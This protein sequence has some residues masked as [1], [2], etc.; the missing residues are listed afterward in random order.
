MESVHASPVVPF[1]HLLVQDAAARR[2]PL[3]V[4]SAHFALIAQAVAVFD[5]AGKNVGDRLNPSV[6]MPRKSG[7]VIPRIV[8]AKI[9]QQKKRIEIL[10]LAEAER[11]LQLDARALDGRLGLNN[12]SN[13]SE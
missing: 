10:R 1:R 13:W 7:Q 3:H 12:L 4:A 5:G 9:I 11:A 8:V 2:H 6:R